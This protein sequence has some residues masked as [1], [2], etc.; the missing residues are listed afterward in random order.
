MLS[1]LYNML[2]MSFNMLYDMLSMLC[3][4]FLVLNHALK[5]AVVGHKMAQKIQRKPQTGQ[6][7]KKNFKS[8]F[9]PKYGHTPC[10]VVA[11]FDDLRP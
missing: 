6:M 11:N 3:L 8:K 7:L 10:T 5:L 4:T 9:Q 2:S 1:M